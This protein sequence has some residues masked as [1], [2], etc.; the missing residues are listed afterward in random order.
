MGG[1]SG[2]SGT[3]R[4]GLFAREKA[5][6]VGSGNAHVSRR[7]H[8]GGSVT[9][10]SH[11][12]FSSPRSAF[13][14]ATRCLPGLRF[15][16]R[17]VVIGY[18]WANGGV[19]C[20]I[21]A[22]VLTG[23]LTFAFVAR[24]G[25]MSATIIRAAIVSLSVSVIPAATLTRFGWPTMVSITGGLHWASG[26]WERFAS[27][28]GRSEEMFLN[29][30]LFVPAGVT[31]TLWRRNPLG[32]LAALGVLS[33]AIEVAQGVLGLGNPDVSDL[34]CNSTGAFVGA[35]IGAIVLMCGRARSRAI[36]WQLVAFGATAACL[37]AAS[38]ALAAHHRDAVVSELKHQFRNDDIRQ[39]RLWNSQG[40]V[41]DH[42]FR[43]A[44]TFSDGSSTRRSTVTVRYPASFLGVQQC[45]Y[46][47][48]SAS[49]VTVSAR[50]G[51]VC[52]VFLG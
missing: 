4:V 29:M 44:G 8:P 21:F 2:D 38:P 45:V 28:L 25:R 51:P 33:A 18:I 48:W 7:H 20:V 50:S 42:V 19:Q 17:C 31:L 41:G 37:V 16:G 47:V 24:K 9:F 26:G 14:D 39:W 27:D 1:S 5:A 10:R 40:T 15:L 30:A 43:A 46:A 35:G 49:G 6:G 12:Q 36:G 23:I 22:L 13:P 3:F 52:T 34:L 11:P 32:A